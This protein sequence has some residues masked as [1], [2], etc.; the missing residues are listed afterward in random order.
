MSDVAEAEP[1]LVI[2]TGG[3]V[4]VAPTFTL[5]NA[6]EVGDAC[7]EAGGGATPVPDS[8]IEID[9]PPPVIV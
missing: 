7:S 2:V 4:L 9:A 6:S 1:V 5:P 8:E 3:R